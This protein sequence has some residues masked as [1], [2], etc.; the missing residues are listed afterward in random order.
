MKI[1]PSTRK[2]S[3]SGGIIEVKTRPRSCAP[4]SVRISGGQ[5]GAA[6]GLM[7]ETMNTQTAYAARSQNATAAP[8]WEWQYHYVGRHARYEGYWV[9]V[10]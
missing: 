5:A 2:I 1:V 10:R 4:R 8:H 7:T 3:T 9:L 6:C